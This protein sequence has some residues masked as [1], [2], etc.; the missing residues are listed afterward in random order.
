MAQFL[1]MFGC[2]SGLV[3]CGPKRGGREN[4]NAVPARANPPAQASLGGRLFSRS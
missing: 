2:I 4:A 3:R 1:C